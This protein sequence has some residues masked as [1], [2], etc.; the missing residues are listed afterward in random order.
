MKQRR[1]RSGSGDVHGY[2]L[3]ETHWR[4]N[5]RPFISS[6]RCCWGRTIRNTPPRL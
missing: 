3:I 2:W 4:S 5:Y 1:V 6:R